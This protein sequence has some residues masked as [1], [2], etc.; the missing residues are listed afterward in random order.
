[1]IENPILATLWPG[2]DTMHCPSCHNTQIVI[3]F[4]K[5]A[6]LTEI[7]DLIKSGNA[8]LVS[9]NTN[10]VQSRWL[11]KTCYDIGEVLTE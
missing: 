4:Y 8:R 1:M 2:K 6:Q 7:F 3:E 10:M 9:S 5:G 11:C